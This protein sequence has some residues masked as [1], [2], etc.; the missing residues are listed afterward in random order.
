MC[1]TDTVVGSDTNTLQKVDTG[2]MTGKLL[3][4]LRDGKKLDADRHTTGALTWR[5]WVP[6]P[7][8]HAGQVGKASWPTPH[9][10][11]IDAFFQTVHVRIV[12][13]HEQNDTCL[14]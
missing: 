6:Q 4:A 12:A 9:S 10:E 11:N 5:R 13:T 3:N 7:G 8:A 1:E 2:T 14:L